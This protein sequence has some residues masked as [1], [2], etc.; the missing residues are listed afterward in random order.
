MPDEKPGTVPETAERTGSALG[1]WSWVERAV[2]TD[3]MLQALEEGVKGGAWYVLMD[4]VCAPQ[5]LAAG[6]AKVAKNRGSAGVDHITIGQYRGGL[7]DNL[8][9]LSKQLRE[10]SYRCH[11]LR[12]VEIPKPGSSEKRTLSI[13]TVRDRIVQAAVTQVLE[14]IFERGFAEHSYGFRPGRGC[15]D[16]LRQ[17]EQ[18]LRAVDGLRQAA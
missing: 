18:W 17:V 13:P 11:A 9:Y 4:K 16:A 12:C 7:S 15:K 1:R 10:G 3:R 14:P 2:W 8:A 6:F 5:N